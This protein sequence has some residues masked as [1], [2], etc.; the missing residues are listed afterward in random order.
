MM[1]HLSYAR[2]RVSQ[3]SQHAVLLD[4]LHRLDQ[5]DCEVDPVNFE[6]KLNQQGRPN[7]GIY[8]INERR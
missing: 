2:P 8:N 3:H 1:T 7:M 6:I 4:R 5:L